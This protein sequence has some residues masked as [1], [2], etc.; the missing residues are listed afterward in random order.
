MFLTEKRTDFQTKLASF[1]LDVNEFYSKAEILVNKNPFNSYIR[2]AK[3]LLNSATD[4]SEV[5][6]VHSFLKNS[7]D[8]SKGFVQKHINDKE[9][10]KKYNA[11]VI[12]AT[13]LLNK[14]IP[15]K[16]YSFKESFD[17]FSTKYYLI[18]E[19]S[20]QDDF[21]DIFNI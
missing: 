3:I 13:D 14:D 19:D 11:F 10:V 6:A 7:L 4:K 12:E 18:E 1:K 20:E 15:E 16:Y 17:Y 9:L 8:Q 2:S 5:S 21:E